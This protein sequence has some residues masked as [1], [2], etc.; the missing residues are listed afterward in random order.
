[1]INK[2]VLMLCQQRMH[3]V[4]LIWGYVNGFGLDGYIKELMCLELS[5]GIRN[6]GN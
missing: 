2:M 3:R 6:I 5:L 1:M 4:H